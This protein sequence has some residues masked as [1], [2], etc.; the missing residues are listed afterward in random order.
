MKKNGRVLKNVRRL[1]RA[2]TYGGGRYGVGGLVPGHE[3][4][5][6]GLSTEGG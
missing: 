2:Q 1:E 6:P 4:D 5:G 3:P